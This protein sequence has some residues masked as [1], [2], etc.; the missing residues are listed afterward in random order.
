MSIEKTASFINKYK[1]N[2]DLYDWDALLD[3]FLKDMEKGLQKER[4]SLRMLPSHF[5]LGKQIKSDTSAALVDAGGTNL[6]I[7][8]ARIDENTECVIEDFESFPIPGSHGEIDKNDFFAEIAGKVKKHLRSAKILSMSIAHP[9]D[10]VSQNKVRLI[11]LVKELQVNGS[12]GCDI[13][14]EMTKALAARGCNG[15]RMHIANDSISTAMAGFRDSIEGGFD[16]CIGVIVGT[17]TN[18]CYPEHCTNIRDIAGPG[19]MLINIECA[20]FDKLPVGAIDESFIASTDDPSSNRLEKIV[21]G[22]Y[23]APLCIEILN[24]ARKEG[25]IMFDDNVLRGSGNADIAEFI[26]KGGRL[27]NAFVDEQSRQS[28]GLIIENVIMRAANIVALE[29]AAASLKSAGSGKSVLAT[30]EGSL[31]YRMPG[32]RQRVEQLTKTWIK[33]KLDIQIELKGYENA[34]LLGSA[35]TASME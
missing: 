16:A 31:Y 28:A 18:A 3:L 8:L 15:I 9:V 33:Q 26:K 17:G 10:I 5:K 20:N 14:A 35:Y 27:W 19:R 21:S 24:T 22:A 4:S 1:L 13:Y 29:L 23:F 11:K 34:V 12:E 7:A 2:G 25:I 32:L 6:R 30:M